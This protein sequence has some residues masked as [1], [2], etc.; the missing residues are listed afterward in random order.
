MS[1]IVV[2]LILLSCAVASLAESTQKA[3]SEPYLIRGQ[4]VTVLF[5][6]YEQ[7]MNQLFDY[8]SESLQDI[9]SVLYEEV[10]AA[11][12]AKES[13]GYQVVPKI[14][15]VIDKPPK[16]PSRPSPAHFNW[17][18]CERSIKDEL[19]APALRVYRAGLQS[20]YQ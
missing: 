2:I 5:D 10:L 17:S 20:H 8:L 1:R 14:S 12:F 16:N 4:E 11:Q 13:D 7:D 3:V 18:I 6:E 15:S 19:G 9:D